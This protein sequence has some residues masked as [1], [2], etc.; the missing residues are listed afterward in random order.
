MS[1]GCWDPAGEVHQCHVPNSTIAS[2][3]MVPYASRLVRD[4]VGQHADRSLEQRFSIKPSVDS[5]SKEA[6]HLVRRKP[7]LDE[8]MSTAASREARWRTNK[9]KRACISRDSHLTHSVG[10]KIYRNVARVVTIHTLDRLRIWRGRRPVSTTIWSDFLESSFRNENDFGKHDR[11]TQKVFF[12]LV[13]PGQFRPLDEAQQASLS[14]VF[15]GV[16]TH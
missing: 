14:G 6:D 10:G 2:A 7:A 1:A 15:T 9:N 4:A 8:S 3:A 16:S 5:G 13:H 12:Y 11:T